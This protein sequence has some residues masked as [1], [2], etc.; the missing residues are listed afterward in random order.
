MFKLFFK[1]AE[2]AARKDTSMVIAGTVASNLMRLFSTVILTRILDPSAYGVVGIINSIGFSVVLLTDVGIFGYVVRH[3]RGNDAAFLN[4]VWTLRAIRCLA[5]MF[6]VMLSAPVFSWALAKPLTLPVAVYALTFGFEALSSMAFAT[7]VRERQMPRL[8]MFDVLP[9]L[10]TLPVAIALAVWLRSYWALIFAM[11]FSSAISAL[12]SY[13]FFPRS[14]RQWAFDFEAA[15]ELWVFGRAIS[16]ASIIHLIIMQTDK[17]VLAAILP[18]AAFGL[19]TVASTLTATVRIFNANYVQRI[20][21]P[22]FAVAKNASSLVQTSVYYGTGRAV[23]LTYA[24]ASG[25]F[26]ACAPLIIEIVFDSRFSGATTFLYLL[27]IG[28]LV[29]MSA[30]AANQMLMALAMT[31]HIFNLNLVR[32]VFLI[33]A[34]SV[35]YYW[36]GPYGIVAAVSGMELAAQGYCWI[37][38]SRVGVF[39]LR[40]EVPY[41]VM[42]MGGLGTGWCVNEIG[43][44][45]ISRFSQ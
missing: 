24:F 9:Q 22:A 32:L 31:R 13:A 45:L 41:W 14:K 25:G 19:Y 33:F 8:M 11:V 4:R 17:I 34:G 6:L 43:I 37:V 5:L 16:G 28:N 27:A 12:L 7:A 44:E 10:I 38:L 20:L 23:R 40:K 42:T 35:G 36:F 21:Y 15:K 30:A 3:E 2:L 1:Q 39:S 29:S 18:L 26:L